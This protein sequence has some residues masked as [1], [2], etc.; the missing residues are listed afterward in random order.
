MR[1]HY[2]FKYA[3][4]LI[5]LLVV[6]SIIAILMTLLTPMISTAI[7]TA[8]R[9]KC[10]SNMRSLGQAFASY[11]SEHN[12]ELPSAHT[13]SG[14]WIECN[15]F[16]RKQKIEGIKR[17]KLWPYVE[18]LSIY[19][20]PGTYGFMKDYVRNYSMVGA[21]DRNLA[22]SQMRWK[23]LSDVM[24]PSTTLLLVEDFDW[25]GYNM[26]SWLMQP[27]ARWY[28]WVDYLPGNH[29]G[30]DNFLFCDGHVEYRRYE[31]PETLSVYDPRH[32]YLPDPDGRNPDMD[33]IGKRY[34]SVYFYEQDGA[35]KDRYKN[36]PPWN[37]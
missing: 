18:D 16:N 36:N 29:R 7:A 14:C 13:G 21:F 9:V 4:S 22:G 2:S 17:G 5:E 26:G 25:R 35:L 11:A 15:S 34:K 33:W 28:Y 3:F 24:R 10:A 19:R 12:G 30:G 8:Q 31:D 20:C 32:F 1:K 6:I 27:S 37:K 23:K